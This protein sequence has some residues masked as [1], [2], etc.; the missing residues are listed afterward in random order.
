MTGQPLDD[1]ADLARDL[2]RANAEAGAA[3]RAAAGGT[4]TLADMA[5]WIAE[6][7]GQP[8]LHRPIFALYAA[9]HAGIGSVATIRAEMEAVAAGDAPI[10]RAAQHLGA[11]LDV[12][13]L[14]ID[15]PVADFLAAPT[16]S[17]RECAATMAFGMEALA[18]QPD[19]LILG[20]LTGDRITVGAALAFALMEGEATDWVL[21]DDAPRIKA[22]V[23][24]A[25]AEAACAP[26]A[27]LRQLGGRET[28]AIAGAILAAR[29][30]GVPVLIE[31]YTALAAGAVLKGLN[32]EA[33]DHCRLPAPPDDPGAR[34]LANALGL[35]PLIDIKTS[36]EDG[37]ASAAALCLIRLACAIPAP[38]ANG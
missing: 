6:W 14:A 25:Q 22:A 9:A 23:A 19:L 7:R 17:E 29:I 24:R 32:P 38:A 27:L 34:M 15:R 37:T 31:G 16:M 28:A 5:G 3:A 11:G 30:Q 33:L 1:I 12:F 26:L 18:K 8:V 13:D 20:A 36:A 2:P 10:S 35:R 4:G 21:E